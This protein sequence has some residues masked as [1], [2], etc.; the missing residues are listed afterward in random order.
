MTAVDLL[1][2]NVSIQVFVPS[3]QLEW[4][5]NRIDIRTTRIGIK[6]MDTEVI[7]NTQTT[8]GNQTNKQNRREDTTIRHAFELFSLARK[9]LVVS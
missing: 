8:S 6:K 9:Q 4:N 1:V 3:S 7:E 2:P 5:H